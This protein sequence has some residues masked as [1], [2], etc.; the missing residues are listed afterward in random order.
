MAMGVGQASGVLAGQ[1][2]HG[3]PFIVAASGTGTIIEWYDFYIF[4]SLATLMSGVFFA[5]GS[6]ALLL[7]LATF[8]AGFAV[9][10]FGAVVFGR[11]G[12]LVGRKYAFLLTI[13]IMGVPAF[14]DWGWRIPFLLSAVLVA[15]SLYIRWKLRETPLFARLKAE[16]RTSKAPLREA[17]ASW[18]NWK[19]ILL[20][21]FGAT[22][23][24]AVVWY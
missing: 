24:Q 3:M 10:P 8:A 18:A 16:G 12:D 2:A 22:A 6:G 14:N 15:V 17:L 4:G 20:A 9:R 5:P 11:I 1:K 21:L 23:G 13:S 7:T 19:L